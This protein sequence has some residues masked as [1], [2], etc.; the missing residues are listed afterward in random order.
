MTALANLENACRRF[1]WVVRKKSP[2]ICDGK[3]RLDMN[4]IMKIDSIQTYND[5]FGVETR[6]P[7]VSV[8]DGREANPL[9]FGRKLYNVYA[10][11]L[12]MPIAEA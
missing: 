9:R 10:V 3:N 6:H 2:Y 5:Y 11:L 8:V 12:K 1:L 4:E 7:L